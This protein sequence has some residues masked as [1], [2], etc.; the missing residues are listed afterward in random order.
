MILNQILRRLTF[1]VLFASASGMFVIGC[2]PATDTSRVPVKGIVLLGDKPLANTMLTFT[3]QNETPGQGGSGRSNAQGDFQIA[4]FDGKAGLTAGDYRVSI[5]KLLRADGSDFPANSE[6]GPMDSDGRE[7]IPE[8]YSD[9]LQT[10]LIAK[11]TPSVGKL[12][13]KV[14]AE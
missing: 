1:V 5:S 3:P 6:L 13:F 11:V 14:T 10:V 2:Q 9:P 8:K 4:G 7:S 12:E